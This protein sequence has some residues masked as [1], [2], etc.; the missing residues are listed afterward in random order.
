M[1]N[2]EIKLPSNPIYLQMLRLSSS[3]ISNS[4]GFDIERIEDIKVIISELFTYLLTEEDEIE[5]IFEI[6]KNKL[7]IVFKRN[8]FEKEEGLNDA[9]FE[10]KKQILI[11]LSD[12][13]VLEDRKITVFMN[14]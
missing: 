4:M 8:K 14:L 9:N 6:Y 11:A 1:D 12:E 2:I 5:V 7:G 3:S 10:L 13:L